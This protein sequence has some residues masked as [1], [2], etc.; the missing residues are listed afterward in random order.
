[1]SPFVVADWKVSISALSLRKPDE[2]KTATCMFSMEGVS[3][4]VALVLAYVPGTATVNLMRALP[5]EG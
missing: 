5:S 2:P 3:A 4:R 1:M